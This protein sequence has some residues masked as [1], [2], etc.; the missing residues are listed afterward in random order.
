MCCSLFSRAAFVLAALLALAARPARA[1]V[2]STTDIISGRITA[3]DGSPL[4]GATV[5]AKSVETSINRTKQSGSDGKYTIVFPDGGGSYQLTIRHIGMAARTLNV[6]RQGDEDQIRVN[7]TMTQNPQRLQDVVV[8]APPQRNQPDRPTPG[9]AERVM[10]ADQVARL[11]LDASDLT[12]LALLAPGVIGVDGTDSTAAAFSVAGQRPDQNNVTL[13]GLTFGSSAVPQDAI[14]NTRVITSTFDVARGQFS[15]GQ[16]ASTTRGGTNDLQG[17]ATYSLRDPSLDVSGE[18]TDVFSRGYEQNS[19]SAGFGGPF[20]QDKFFGFGAISFRRRS[21]ALQSLIVAD[22]TTLERLGASPD[23]VARFLNGLN[24]Y[25]LTPTLPGIPNDR[26]T[27]NLQL[28]SRLD[29]FVTDEHTL[30]VRFDYRRNSVDATRI[31]TFGLPAGGGDQKSDGGGAMVMLTSHLGSFVN[32]LRAYASKGSAN[33]LPYQELPS[34]RV[35]L[36]SALDDGTIGISVLQ[37]GG[38]SGLPTSTLNNG[39]EAS[40]ELSWLKNG[41]RLK[42]GMLFNTGDFTQTFTPNQFGTFTYASLADYVNNVPSQFTRTL[43]STKKTGASTNGA[44]YLGDTWRM[45]NALQLI[46]GVRME[47]SRYGDAPAFNDSVH[48]YFGR[49][50]NFFPS[51]VHV[52]PRVGFSWT[53]GAPDQG[54]GQGGF[55]GQQALGTLRGGIGEF[56]GTVPTS[57]FSAAQSATGLINA[58][59][60]LVCIGPAVPTPDFPGYEQSLLSIPTECADGFGSGSPFGARPNVTTFDQGFGAP[61]SWR[62]SLGLQRRFWQR[63]GFSID[64]SYARGV[65]Q[66]GFRDLNLDDAPKFTLGREGNRPVYVDPLTIVPTTGQTAS[67]FS[68]LRP[69]YGQ[70]LAVSSDLQSE[71]K[72][73]TLGINGFTMRGILFQ[74][75]YTYSRSRDQSSFGGGLGGAG[76]GANTGADPNVHEWSTSDLERRHSMVG[77]L[78]Y[79]V[80]PW[81]ELTTVARLSSGAP[82]T[83]LVGSDINGD[84]QRNDRAFIFNP[85]TTTDTAVSN[86]MSRLLAGAP[87]RVKG[88][89]TRAFEQV[90][91]RNSCSGP[92]TPSLDLQA[93]FRPS[94]LGLDRRLTLSLLTVNLLTGVDQ[95]VHGANN[96]SGWGQSYRAD[97]TLLYVRGFDPATNRYVYQVNERFGVSHG[98]INAIRSPFQVSFQAR[99]ALGRDQTRDRINAIFQRG[100]R[101][102]AGG[103]VSGFLARIAPNPI[104]SILARTDTL[105]LT[106]DQVTRL[107]ALRDTL[108]AKNMAIADTVRAAIEKLGANPDMQSLFAQAA[109][110]LTEARANIESALKSAQSL[111]TPEQWGKLPQNVRTPGRGGGGQGGGRRP[112]QP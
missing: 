43:A 100:G 20:I 4:A 17:S 89:L 31:S 32:E 2:G 83:P 62:G 79:P 96:L 92:W 30:M 80:N 87:G 56:R 44:I 35:Q 29:Y 23:S 19:L 14:R 70:V 16:I 104:D 77:T 88:C 71:T 25:G 50:T 52:S 41:H 105:K 107:T 27:D 6:S 49:N 91:G 73:L 54:A 55:G 13:D 65:N 64:A 34:G 94:F 85:A 47:G 101:D 33:S 97:P 69:Q 7:V 58:Q 60:Q 45:S 9:S 46:Y 48:S 95:L 82:V 84:G 99:Y 76:V 8:R 86:G 59:S 93:N 109:P 51:E 72:Q 38:N 11:P 81:L 39:V 21:D 106:T 15:G 26:R 75:S 36:S 5:T 98:S 90:A 67:I 3:P 102:G 24:S 111:L 108:N 18:G 57:L 28:F 53:I 1:Q 110:K 74:A 112:P 37:F 66:Y 10:T 78:S 12:A 63:Y 68:R 40:E 103:G 61:R 42:L 22:P